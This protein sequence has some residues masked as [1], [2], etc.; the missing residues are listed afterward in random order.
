[1]PSRRAHSGQ[2]TELIFGGLRIFVRHDPL[3]VGNFAPRVDW[4]YDNDTRRGEVR[5][6]CMPAGWCLEF[7]LNAFG[8]VGAPYD[9][10]TTEELRVTDVVGDYLRRIDP[11]RIRRALE[12]DHQ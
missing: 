11:D 4:A 8:S 1:M 6:G 7:D 10:M 3:M 12:G 2:W 9:R 5:G